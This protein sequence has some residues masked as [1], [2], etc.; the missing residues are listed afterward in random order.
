MDVLVKQLTILGL[1]DG[2]RRFRG[3]T[4]HAI[5]L[6]MAAWRE[7]LDGVGVL[8]WLISDVLRLV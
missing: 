2:L 7:L 6:Q 1:S 4:H 5:R 8:S 3:A